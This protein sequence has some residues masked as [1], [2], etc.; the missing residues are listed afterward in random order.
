MVSDRLSGLGF[1]VP[2]RIIPASRKVTT[3]KKNTIQIILFFLLILSVLS[4]RF[5][6]FL[7]DVFINGISH[8]G[9]FL[10]V[11]GHYVV[12]V[13]HRIVMQIPGNTDNLPR[14]AL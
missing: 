14:F 3:T 8:G 7:N 5:L 9:E 4:S 6:Y 11:F 2:R 10:L 12:F 1:G 13:H